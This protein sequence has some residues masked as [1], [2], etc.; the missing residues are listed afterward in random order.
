MSIG[1]FNPAP[2]S[3]DGAQRP[4]TRRA[5]T[6]PSYTEPPFNFTEKALVMAM[7]QETIDRDLARLDQLIEEQEAIFIADRPRAA[8]LQRRAEGA[9]AGGVTSSWQQSHPQ[10]VWISHGKGSKIWDVDGHEL[11]DLHN[12]YGVMAV[13]HA[14]PVIVEAIASRAGQG[15]HFAQPTEDAIVVA[16]NLAERFG[17]PQ[18]RFSN[19]G[20]EATM[21]AVHLMR[22]ATGRDFIVKIEGTYH[23]HHD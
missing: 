19:S 2:P 20:T 4:R 12:G 7:Q 22:A 5:G 10:P 17:L 6:R 21:D 9:L 11:V 14:H 1:A 13:G 8:E 3:S 18:W 15:T 16:E 23:G